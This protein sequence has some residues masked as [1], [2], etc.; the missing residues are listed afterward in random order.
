M[1]GWLHYCMSAMGGFFGAFALMSAAERFANAQTGNLLDMMIHLADGNAAEMLARLGALIMYIAG[2]VAADLV[3]RHTGICGRKL[4]LWVD[5]GG[6]LL[7]MALMRAA[8]AVHPVAALY[9]VFFVTAFQW[10][11]YGGAHGFSSA[12]LFSTN[13]LKQCVTGWTEY[14]VTGDPKMKE[15]GAF[16]LFT[17]LFFMLG[18]LYGATALR[19]WSLPGA[20]AGLLPLGIAR[21]MLFIKGKN[22]IS[23]GSL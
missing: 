18:A 14:F 12:S 15:K 6:L 22:R 13:N 1:D 3:D 19:R 23:P 5:A 2:L 10:T 16:Y 17:L 11:S 4:S 20:L 8:S 9:P 7:S 21:I